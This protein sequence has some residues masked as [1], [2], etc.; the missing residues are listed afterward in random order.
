[1]RAP[2][3]L[4]RSMAYLIMKRSLLAL[5][6]VASLTTLLACRATTERLQTPI[7]PSPA[8]AASPSTAERWAA[9]LTD[10]LEHNPEVKRAWTDFERS[11]KYRMAKPS[12]R[13]L[14]QQAQARVDRSRPNQIIPFLNWWGARGYEGKTDFLVVIVVDPTRSDPKRY[15]LVVF[16][17][18]KSEGPNFKPYWV[19]RE[20][21]LESY[22]LSVASGTFW[23]EG[24]S[25]D[26]TEQTKELAWNLSSVSLD[27]MAHRTTRW[28]GVP[29]S[30]ESV[31]RIKPV[32]RRLGGDA[33]PG[34]L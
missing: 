20:A 24:F 22:L 27:I 32:R 10:F 12:D 13:N 3:E 28:T 31:F 18:P 16:A 23:V 8:L 9:D 11:Q 29:T 15:G 1:V 4:N 25:R 2:A 17:A 14:T 21:N 5:T 30:W 26:G 19:L 6:V 7:P 33:P 34:Q